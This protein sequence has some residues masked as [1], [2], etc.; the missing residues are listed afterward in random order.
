MLFLVIHNSCSERRGT[1]TQDV[2]P[3]KKEHSYCQNHGPA[4]RSK[5]ILVAF[6]HLLLQCL[7]SAFHQ[8]NPIRIREKWGPT[9]VIFEI[10]LLGQ[11]GGMTG[12]TMDLE[13]KWRM[14]SLEILLPAEERKHVVLL[15]ILGIL[16]IIGQGFCYSVAFGQ[17][18]LCQMRLGLMRCHLRS[19]NLEPVREISSTQQYCEQA[20]YVISLS[21][22]FITW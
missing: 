7:A 22:S 15:L 10:R 16:R 17:H 1:A 6:P 18:Q 8:Q 5:D 11:D 21:L 14:V 13:G 9:K 20:S 3:Q 2:L 4:G 19:W 12:Q